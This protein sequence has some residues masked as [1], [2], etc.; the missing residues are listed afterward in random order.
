GAGVVAHRAFAERAPFGQTSAV[1]P[2][3]P[4]AAVD[5][6]PLFADDDEQNPFLA[7]PKPAGKEERA[8]PDAAGV[9]VAVS[10]DGKKFMIEL[11]SKIK[12]ED[13]KKLE[14]KITDKTA[15]TY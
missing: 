11:A 10:P 13:A 6:N 7:D 9:V 3:A 14:I 4:L 12:G 1:I 8:K 5:N 2:P 15:V